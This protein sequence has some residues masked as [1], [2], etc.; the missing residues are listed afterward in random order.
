MRTKI[1]SVL[2]ALIC[3]LSLL[4]PVSLAAPERHAHYRG[5]FKRR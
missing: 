5:S 1:L 2:L 3:I 4:A